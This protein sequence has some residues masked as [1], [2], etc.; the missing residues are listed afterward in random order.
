MLP[1]MG[2]F[3]MNRII[4]GDCIEAMQSLPAASVDMVFADPPYNL[5]LEGELT[6]PTTAGSTAS[7]RPGTASTISPATTVSARPGSAR[8]G[9]S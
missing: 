7:R 8:R 1:L 6:A 5:Q 9:A 4:S 2:D 3:S